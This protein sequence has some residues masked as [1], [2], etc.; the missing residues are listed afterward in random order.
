M[1][2][3]LCAL[4]LLSTA[5]CCSGNSTPL[6][7]TPIKRAVVSGSASLVAHSSRFVLYSTAV[8]GQLDLTVS[9]AGASDTVWVDMALTANCS[10][11]QF[12]AGTCQF[13]TS[14]RSASTAPQKTVS[15]PALSPGAYT[16][17]IDNRGPADESV[18][19]EVDLTS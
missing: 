4:A 9:W 11:D 6:T 3:R 5:T 7:P 15:I 8:Q 1:L 13:I 16:L 2:K 17:F 18:T 14:N 12:V 19:Y 10:S